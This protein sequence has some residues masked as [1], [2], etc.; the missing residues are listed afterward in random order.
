[1]T[2]QQYQDRHDVPGGGLPFAAALPLLKAGMR[3]TRRAWPGTQWLVLVPGST[4][5]V[6]ADRPMGQ[7]APDLVNRKVAY[8][9][10][11]DIV[12]GD[13]LAAPWHPTS[14]D[15]LADDWTPVS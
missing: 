6:T 5:T 3:V 14:V 10:H 13:A 12:T 4:F 11:I 1:M 9:P 2:D 7:A 15:L 8:Q